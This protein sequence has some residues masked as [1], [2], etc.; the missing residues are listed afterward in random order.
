[1][2]IPVVVSL[3]EPT[4]ANRTNAPLQPVHKRANFRIA[5]VSRS[6]SGEYMLS[7]GITVTMAGGGKSCPIA[8]WRQLLHCST[9]TRLVFLFYICSCFRK[10]TVSLGLCIAMHEVV[11]P[12]NRRH[13]MSAVGADEQLSKRTARGP[14]YAP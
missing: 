11:R 13:A 5:R 10:G 8:N 12:G 7:M 14:A 2:A 4:H 3:R 1:M 9:V 6:H